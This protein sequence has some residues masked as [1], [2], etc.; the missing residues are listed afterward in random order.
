MSRPAIRIEIVIKELFAHPV[1]VCIPCL[2]ALNRRTNL[3]P[4]RHELKA[5]TSDIG[6]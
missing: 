1:H 6:H 5:A 3:G 4:S 2:P